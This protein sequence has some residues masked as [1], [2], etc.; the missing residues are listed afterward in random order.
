MFPTDVSVKSIF[1]LNSQQDRP[2]CLT[3]PN[4]CYQAVSC[5]NFFNHSTPLSHTFHGHLLSFVTMF[6]FY[7]SIIWFVGFLSL[8]LYVPS[9]FWLSIL[10][11]FLPSSLHFHPFLSIPS[12]LWL[13]NPS[14]SYYS[15]IMAPF[16]TLLSPFVLSSMTSFWL[17]VT[18]SFDISICHHH[19]HLLHQ[20]KMPKRKVR[21]QRSVIFAQGIKSL[22]SSNP[23]PCH[24]ISPIIFTLKMNDLPPKFHCTHISEGNWTQMQ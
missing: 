22:P 6:V 2:K 10:P 1:S 24:L 14:L 3:V 15:S 16:S 18:R 20:I 19:H 11:H 4:A 8:T 17:H 21:S 5:V 7:L 23:T 9:D 13:F 12:T